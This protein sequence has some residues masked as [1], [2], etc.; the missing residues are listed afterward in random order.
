MIPEDDVIQYRKTTLD[1][2]KRLE[3]ELLC[4]RGRLV[5]INTILERD[6]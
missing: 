5:A 6:K 1:R 4:Q 2:I 3:E